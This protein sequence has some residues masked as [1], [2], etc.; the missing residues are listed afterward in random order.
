VGA[1]LRFLAFFVL[2]AAVLILVVLPLALSALLT[3]QVRD[4]GLRS[5]TLQVNLAL[6]DPSL[7]FG[8]SKRISLEATNVEVT[9]GQ[10]G[11]LSLGLNNA[12]YF[13]QS[14][15]TVSG[16]VGDIAVRIGGEE[17]S[18]S[19]IAIDG[20]ADE[21]GATA[22]LSTE[23]AERLVRAAARRTGITLDSVAL[24][25]SGMTVRIRG[26]EATAGVAVR[27]G[28]LL[29]EPRGADAIVLVQATPS[30]PWRLE[31]AWVSDSGLN[32]RATID[33]ATLAAELRSGS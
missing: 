28:A 31:E 4:A 19:E 18:A 21:A 27:G 25:G 22:R 10:I 16:T 30:D 5:E 29:L 7:L 12:D 23:E 17:L 24:N 33:F 6:F 14:F 20:P 1:F 2:L 32:V 26:L 9:G 15:E 13:D 11:T 8:R 3:Q